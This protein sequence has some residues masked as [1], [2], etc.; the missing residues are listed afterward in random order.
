MNRTQ[1]FTIWRRANA[2]RLIIV[3][4]CVSLAM[5]LS[6]VPAQ[7]VHAASNPTAPSTA[8]KCKTHLSAVF[9]PSKFDTFTGHTSRNNA[10]N[11]LD[12]NFGV[13]TAGKL[14]RYFKTRAEFDKLVAPQFLTVESLTTIATRAELQCILPT[15]SENHRELL[16]SA[17]LRSLYK[18]GKIDPSD[19]LQ[20]DALLY[21]LEKIAV[22]KGPPF[23]L[24]ETNSW[25]VPPR[26]D[27]V[28]WVGTARAT[29]PA[30]KTCED[31]KNQPKAENCL[32]FQDGT[33]YDFPPP[34]KAILSLS[35]CLRIASNGTHKIGM[36]RASSLLRQTRRAYCVWIFR[37]CIRLPIRNSI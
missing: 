3:L 11:W 32:V 20:I 5:L 8:L 17:A 21:Y 10:L 33:T 22:A 15:I 23:Y 25:D 9:L 35:C 34:P 4:F 30:L 27:V 12:Q 6:D 16:D 13:N 28:D 7:R 36:T 37:W 2:Y 18:L 19:N 14:L 1:S 24:K 26:G 31:K 29:T